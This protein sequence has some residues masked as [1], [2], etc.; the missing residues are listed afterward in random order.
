MLTAVYKYKNINESTLYEIIHTLI[1]HAKYSLVVYTAY[2][3]FCR[4][5]QST[6]L[7]IQKAAIPSFNNI[8]VV[9]YFFQ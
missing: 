2:S 3:Y 6:L 9:I 1:V 4:R 5:G 8:V 7:P